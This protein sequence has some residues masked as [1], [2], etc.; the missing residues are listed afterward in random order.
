MNMY[1][2]AKKDIIKEINNCLECMVV[3]TKE[4]QEIFMVKESLKNKLSLLKNNK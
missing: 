2:L 3:F 1:E 4:E